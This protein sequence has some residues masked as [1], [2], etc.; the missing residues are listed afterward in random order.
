LEGH[1]K[2][3]RALHLNE[4]IVH[5]L[6]CN[7]VAVGGINGFLDLAKGALAQ[8]LPHLV[9]PDH[10]LL[11]VGGSSAAIS[12][13]DRRVSAVGHANAVSM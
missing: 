1:L 3:A 13:W 9:L 7:H 4:C 6:N 2:T 5:D 11:F 10:F 8:Q 12:R